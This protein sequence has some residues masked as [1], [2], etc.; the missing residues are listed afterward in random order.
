[1]DFVRRF[2]ALCPH[3]HGEA[4]QG[5]FEREALHEFVLDGSLRFYCA[6]CNTEWQ[7]SEQELAGIQQLL[8]LK[9]RT[10]VHA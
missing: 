10:L 9:D 7:P 1:M 3:C 8:E 2:S 4:D 5:T 6:D